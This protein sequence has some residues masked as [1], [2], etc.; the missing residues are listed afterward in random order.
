MPGPRVEEGDRIEVVRW[1][2]AAI[3][4]NETVPPGTKGTV[5]GYYPNVDQVWVEWDNG[6]NLC[7]VISHDT[8]RRS[9]SEQE[10]SNHE[11]LTE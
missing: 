8:W 11:A 9:L 10:G 5:N 3:D 2:P 6:T 1:G 7:L 4:D